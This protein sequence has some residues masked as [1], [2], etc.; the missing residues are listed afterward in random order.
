VQI[1]RCRA[2]VSEDMATGHWIQF[3]EGPRQKL[4]SVTSRRG[5][6]PS[7][8]WPTYSLLV[9]QETGAN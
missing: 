3:R 9:S 8:L 4:E 1:P 2:T 6:A 7:T 5:E